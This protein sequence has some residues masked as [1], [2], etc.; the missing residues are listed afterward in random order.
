MLQKRLL[1]LTLKLPTFQSFVK[2]HQF[3]ISYFNIHSAIRREI[4]FITFTVNNLKCA[5]LGCSKKKD[6]LGKTFLWVYLTY[7]YSTF[8]SSCTVILNRGAIGVVRNISKR[9]GS[10]NKQLGNTKLS[11]F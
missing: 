1:H 2:K 3:S 4:L 9:T 8:L 11:F 6:Q 7:E 10:G 5:D